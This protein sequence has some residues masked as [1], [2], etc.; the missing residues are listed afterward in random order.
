MTAFLAISF[1]ALA[2]EQRIHFP[3]TDDR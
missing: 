2:E 3:E 1:E